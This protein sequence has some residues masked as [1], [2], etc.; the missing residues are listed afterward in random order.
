M[1][2]AALNAAGSPAAA[3]MSAPLDDNREAR[4]SSDN[5]SD[6]GVMRACRGAQGRLGA[7]KLSQ[8]VNKR[9]CVGVLCKSGWRLRNDCSDGPQPEVPADPRAGADERCLHPEDVM[10]SSGC[11]LWEN[12]R[13]PRAAQGDG[14]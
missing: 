12:S 10:T 14:R 3:N 1:T 2:P 7:K 5:S 6:D 11:S 4:Q 13:R 8:N 9:K